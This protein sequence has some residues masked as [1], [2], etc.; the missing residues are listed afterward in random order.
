VYADEMFMKNGIF[1]KLSFHKQAYDVFDANIKHE[2]LEPDER[3]YKEFV[4]NG[5]FGVTL[6]HD[7]PMYIKSSRAL[8]TPVY[9][10]PIVRLVVEGR[11][12]LATVVDYRF[13]IAYRYECFANGLQSSIKYYA[14]R[15]LPS[16]L[17]QDIEL[18]NPTDS[19]LYAKLYQR[20]Y[21]THAWSMYSSRA[22]K[23]ANLTPP[24]LRYYFYAR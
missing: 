6:D 19:V 9:W 15:A 22:V 18:K 1:E 4:G 14:F 12:Q 13:G 24:R 11:S 10:H 3:P 2:P 8:S 17:V 16:V 21:K 7:S 23:Y 5:Y 20:P